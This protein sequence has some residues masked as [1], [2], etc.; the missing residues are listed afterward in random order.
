LPPF[1]EKNVGATE[2]C[3]GGR[4]GKLRHEFLLPGRGREKVGLAPSQGPPLFV[5]ASGVISPRIR[6]FVRDRA[7]RRCG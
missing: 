1:V 7:Q 6:Q 4:L 3:G 2:K 5:R